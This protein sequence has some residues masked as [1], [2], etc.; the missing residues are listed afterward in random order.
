MTAVI[1]TGELLGSLCKSFGVDTYVECSSHVLQLIKENL[2]RNADADLGMETEESDEKRTT[3]RKR[4][5]QYVWAF[6]IYFILDRLNL[7]VVIINVM[8]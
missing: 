5:S 1:T 6:L 7:N 2:S 4:V 8:G 3:S